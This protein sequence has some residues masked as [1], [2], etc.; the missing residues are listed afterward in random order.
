MIQIIETHSGRT[1]RPHKTLL[2]HVRGYSL[3]IW[4]HA[5]ERPWQFIG[6]G[7]ACVGFGV[8][9]INFYTPEAFE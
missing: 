4:V 7:V 9:S 2:A 1:L 5:P 6:D 3:F 8:V